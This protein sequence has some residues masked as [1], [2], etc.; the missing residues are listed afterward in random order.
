MVKGQSLHFFN[1]HFY[2]NI[3]SESEKTQIRQVSEIDAYMKDVTATKKAPLLLTCDCNSPSDGVVR[4]EML[5]LAFSDSWS[6]T[7]SATSG[8]TGGQNLDAKIKTATSRIDYIFLK[9][10]SPAS[11]NQVPEN[12]AKTPV[13][14]TILWPSDHLG[15][16]VE[17][18]N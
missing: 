2:T 18:K 8:F 3:S 12:P 7:N 15:V 16:V 11:S 17:F 4:A 10:I 13:A 6:A 14:G 1:S 5:K 9:D